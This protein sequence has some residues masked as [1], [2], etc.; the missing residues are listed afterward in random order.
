MYDCICSYQLGW[1]YLHEEWVSQLNTDCWVE[2]PNGNK[3]IS[4]HHFCRDNRM[5]YN[6]VLA[7]KLV[8][9]CEQKSQLNFTLNRIIHNKR[10]KDQT[11]NPI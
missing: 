9:S 4:I 7:S 2:L 11:Y 8:Y 1:N 3:T 5:M 6:F 10:V